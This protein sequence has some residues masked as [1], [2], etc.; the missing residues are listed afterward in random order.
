MKQLLRPEVDVVLKNHPIDKYELVFVLRY[1]IRNKLATG[2][3]HALTILQNP[4]F[5]LDELF[6]KMS[7]TDEEEISINDEDDN[8]EDNENKAEET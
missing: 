5:D 2:P 1:M 4:N 7:G 3:N 6:R 8:N